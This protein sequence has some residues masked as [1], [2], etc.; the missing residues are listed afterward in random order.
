MESHVVIKSHT[1]GIRLVL[2]PEVS[3][4]DLLK[5]TEHKFSE[6]R[7]FLGD[8]SLVLAIEGRNLSN[9]EEEKLL[10]CIEKNCNL[11]ILCVVGYDEE[12]EQ[13][14]LH[15][16]KTI[17]Q[18]IDPENQCF[19]YRGSVINHQDLE[20]DESV[21]ILG[22]VNQGSSVSSKGNVVVLGGLYGKARAGVATDDSVFVIALEMAPEELEIGGVFY[23]PE[24]K[25]QH[26][27]KKKIEPKLAH[28][29]EGRIELEELSRP[30]IERL[31]GV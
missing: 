11:D 13:T 25:K 29:Q 23:E 14:F 24:T 21:I 27:L 7:S 26:F 2:D 31:Y 19:F 18:K 9:Y 4:E 8:Q 28:V 1:H 10:S 15:A 17:E 22:D 16:I 6:A 20:F 5:E 12:A 30:V 3:F